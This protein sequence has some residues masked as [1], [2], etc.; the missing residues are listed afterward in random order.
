MLFIPLFYVYKA[1]SFI[2][3]IEV[4]VLANYLPQ[5][6]SFVGKEIRLTKDSG[7]IKGYIRIASKKRQ[8][9]T[10]EVMRDIREDTAKSCWYSGSKLA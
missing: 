10:L 4:K 5:L 7:D 1:K 9:V 2:V 8:E 6:G 3:V